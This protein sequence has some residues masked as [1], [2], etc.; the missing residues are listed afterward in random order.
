MGGGSGLRLLFLLLRQL[1][2][3]SEPRLPG[4]LMRLKKIGRSLPLCCL[5]GLCSLE[6][7]G[8]R[9]NLDEGAQSGFQAHTNGPGSAAP[10]PPPSLL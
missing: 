4:P 6:E 8:V 7:Q 9:G 5:P 2:Q 3:G 1:S 10:L